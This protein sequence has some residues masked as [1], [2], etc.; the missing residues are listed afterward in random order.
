M[1]ELSMTPQVFVILSGLIEERL[2]LWYG[3]SDKALLESKL[4]ARMLEL[5]VDSALDYY[6]LLRYDDPAG[7]E[8]ALLTE[9]LVVNET[10]F[11]R[12]YDQ[13][14]VV[15]AR[16]VEPLARARRKPRVWCAA[17]ATGEEPYTIAFWLAERGL[18]D[19]VQLMASDVSDRVLAVARAGQYRARSL[20]QVPADVDPWRWL[21]RAGDTWVVDPEICAAIEWR[22]VNL[23]EESAVIAM[24]SVDVIICRN[25]LIY[26]RDDVVRRTVR[27]LADRL[28][29][30]GLLLVG[31]TESPLR[32]GTD[33][34]CQEHGRAFVYRKMP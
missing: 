33:L 30:G 11:F 28:L 14:Q 22:R 7:S 10:Y 12:E 29:P 16:F 27:W 23:M 19:H 15:L 32:L 26:F 18:L 3:L 4:S 9:S 2:G 5:G 6:Y 17:C 24:G 20:R 25:V 34:V 31:V 8:L 1:S 21:C 13:L